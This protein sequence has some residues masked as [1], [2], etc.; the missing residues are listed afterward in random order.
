MARCGSLNQ[1]NHS[2]RQLNFRLRMR[3]IS[4]P[5]VSVYLLTTISH[6]LTRCKTGHF[7]EGV[8]DLSS[9]KDELVPLAIEVSDY[10]IPAVSPTR[11]YWAIALGHIYN[12]F[13]IRVPIN[14]RELLILS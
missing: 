1:H 13:Y 14:L 2:I 9:K 12:D 8:W 3:N 4:L 6:G 11:H 5:R 10:S 7:Y